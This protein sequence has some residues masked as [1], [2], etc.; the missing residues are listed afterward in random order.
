MLD[1]EGLTRS[2]KSYPSFLKFF[3]QWIANILVIHPA[4][5]TSTPL[6]YA[7]E[8]IEE[9]LLNFYL[10]RRD[11]ADHATWIESIADILRVSRGKYNK[12]VS[13]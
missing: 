8:S 6:C 2:P 7:S 10:S 13:Q 12:H 5:T 1:I 4:N 3:N 9:A 11:L